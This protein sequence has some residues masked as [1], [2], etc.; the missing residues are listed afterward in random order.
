MGF[1]I[2]QVVQ[3]FQPCLERLGRNPGFQVEELVDKSTKTP[4]TREMNGKQVKSL[5]RVAKAVSFKVPL[6]DISPH[7][8][9][10]RVTGHILD[11]DRVLCI[12]ALALLLNPC[13][14]LLRQQKMFERGSA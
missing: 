14:G 3:A 9:V 13:L 6:L 4:G 8:R 2:I 7:E 1:P 12:A 11:R 10:K 5:R